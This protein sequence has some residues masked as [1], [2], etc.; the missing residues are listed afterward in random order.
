MRVENKFY[1]ICSDYHRWMS[2]PWP[3]LAWPE[4][5]LWIFSVFALKIGKEKFAVA[6]VRDKPVPLIIHEM[7]GICH[8]CCLGVNLTFQATA[9][10]EPFGRSSSS[11]EAVENVQR[12][13]SPKT[14]RDSNFRIIDDRILQESHHQSTWYKLVCC[15]HRY[16]DRPK[17]IT[18]CWQ[19]TCIFSSRA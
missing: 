10:T 5:S 9:W 8:S 15:S 1:A 16:D 7:E 19:M 3:G 18:Q 2:A 6:H 12:T 11:D 17:F 4:R 13:L 14:P